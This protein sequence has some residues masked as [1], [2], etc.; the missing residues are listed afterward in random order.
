MKKLLSLL[1]I[2]I[3][4][5]VLASLSPEK[6]LDLINKSYTNLQS[7]QVTFT[8]QLYANASLKTLVE[9]T[10]GT[11]VKSGL[12]S[13]QKSL[14]TEVLI[15]KN[16]HLLI[17]HEDKFISIG[18]PVQDEEIVLDELPADLINGLSK[19]KKLS[20]AK[21]NDKENQISYTIEESPFTQIM[22]KY[23]VKSH[24]INA[25]HYQFKDSEILE[26]LD[27]KEPPYLVVSCKTNKLNKPISKHFF[28]ETR[29]VQIKNKR[30]VGVGALKN[31]TI[32]NNL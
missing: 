5:T 26:E 7:F 17:S 19:A 21:I 32:Y 11:Y 24:L 27:L 14:N 15:N 4:G 6:E 9:K 12:N 31:Y 28:D 22:I 1:G 18:H 3:A 23:N 20:I 25:F 16:Y 2:T 13:Y 29:F 8:H 10:E 30:V